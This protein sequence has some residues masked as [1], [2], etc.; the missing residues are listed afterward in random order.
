MVS[1]TGKRTGITRRHRVDG[2]S[3]VS[4]GLKQNGRV[5]QA[6]LT[7][8]GVFQSWGVLEDDDR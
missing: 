3:E 2:I 8:S 1:T 4:L 7:W 6:G 5:I